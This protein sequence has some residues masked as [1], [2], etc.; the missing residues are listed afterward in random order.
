MNEKVQADDDPRDGSR[1]NK[2]GVAEESSSTMVVGVE[3]G[4]LETSAG[5]FR[6]VCFESGRLTERLLLDDEENGVEEF[7]VLSDVVEL[8]SSHVSFPATTVA[9]ASGNPE[10]LFWWLG[11]E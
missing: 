9:A 6:D 11:V 2:L 10:S 7:N 4:C 3:E 5:L 8:D 1:S